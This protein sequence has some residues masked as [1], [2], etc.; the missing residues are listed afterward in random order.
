MIKYLPNIIN[1][2]LYYQRELRSAIREGDKDKA[3]KY[4]IM[5]N[6]L[7]PVKYRIETS[8]LPL[9]ERRLI[10]RISYESK[11]NNWLWSVL[12][13]LEIKIIKFRNNN[14]KV[15]RGKK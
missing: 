6:E 2:F 1:R 5:I 15:W 10:D 11:V 14:W 12:T 3:S 13:K 7:L 9:L 8:N 4:L